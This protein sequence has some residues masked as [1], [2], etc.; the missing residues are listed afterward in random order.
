MKLSHEAT[1]AF[2]P[3][4]KTSRKPTQSIYSLVFTSQNLF[5]P[6]S[7]KKIQTI[8]FDM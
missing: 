8:D 7:P 5:N 1:S 3:L 2:D 4:E 6:L